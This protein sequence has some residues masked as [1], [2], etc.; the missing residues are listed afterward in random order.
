MKFQEVLIQD[1]DAQN[2][3]KGWNAG[4]MNISKKISWWLHWN[5]VHTVYP[6]KDS[7]NTRGSIVPELTVL[8]CLSAGNGPPFSHLCTPRQ[9]SDTVW[10]PQGQGW[11]QHGS[12]TGWQ[13]QGHGRAAALELCQWWHKW[14]QCTV[15][16]WKC[17]MGKQILS[18]GYLG[19]TGLNHCSRHRFFS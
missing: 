3:H 5:C 18:T 11:F 16:L 17:P 8:S 10:L 7:I 15:H 4:T 19:E 12:D 14:G 6:D 2:T 1:G 9:G 13:R